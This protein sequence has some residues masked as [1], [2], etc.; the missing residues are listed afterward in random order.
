MCG[1]GATP[2]PMAG[3]AKK[4]TK[5]KPKTAGTKKAVKKGAKKAKK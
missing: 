2:P 5:P 1:C 4:A 3:G